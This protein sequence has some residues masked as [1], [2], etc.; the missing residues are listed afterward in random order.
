MVHYP[1]LLC[2]HINVKKDTENCDDEMYFCIYGIF[3]LS[4]SEVQ[5]KLAQLRSY[6]PF[7]QRMISKLEVRSQQVGA[8]HGQL[9][10]LRGLHGFLTNPISRA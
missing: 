8:S 7:V 6:V 10:R 3:V 4:F 9:E 1:A 2:E 5:E